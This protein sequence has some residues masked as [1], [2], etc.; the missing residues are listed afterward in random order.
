MMCSDS[1]IRPMVNK[2]I[3]IVALLAMFSPLVVKAQTSYDTPVG[4]WRTISD[5]TGKQDGVVEIVDKGGELLG[6][7]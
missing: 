5:V 3:L 6:D 2:I 4:R 1:A 7:G